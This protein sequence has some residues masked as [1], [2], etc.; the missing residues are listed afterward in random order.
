[1]DAEN[2]KNLF[3]SLCYPTL[4]ETQNGTRPKK[5]VQMGNKWRAMG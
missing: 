5:E 4:T 3:L 2:C 1:M